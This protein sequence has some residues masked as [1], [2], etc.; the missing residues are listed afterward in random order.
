MIL[1]IQKIIADDITLRTLNLFTD[2]DILTKA[3]DPNKAKANAP[4]NK[5]WPEHVY[6]AQ[7]NQLTL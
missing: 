3:V 4:K 1:T 5:N 6:L 2:S 7:L